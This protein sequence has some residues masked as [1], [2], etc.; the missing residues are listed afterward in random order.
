[1]K[2]RDKRCGSLVAYHERIIGFR[3]TSPRQKT[4]RDLFG[5]DRARAAIGSRPAT[6]LTQPTS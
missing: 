3:A 5:S 1:M 6:G 2:I 4:T